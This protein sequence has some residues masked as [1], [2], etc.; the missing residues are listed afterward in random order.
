MAKKYVVVG[1]D[2]DPCPRCGRPTQIREHK[3]IEPRH[4][5]Q[6]FYYTRWFNCTASD[7][8]TTL[9]MPPP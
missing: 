1:H 6:S 4:L 2:G 9:I 5:Q 8:R 7:C 3:S